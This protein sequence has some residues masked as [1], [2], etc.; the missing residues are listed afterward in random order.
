MNQNVKYKNNLQMLRIQHGLTQRQAA[1]LLGMKIEDRL[2]HWE[3]G[4]SLPHM[5]NLIKLC[6][7]YR[8]LPHEIYS[9]GIFD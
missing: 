8:V 6:R 7:L 9:E 4:Y 2:S 1:A 5:K 3:R